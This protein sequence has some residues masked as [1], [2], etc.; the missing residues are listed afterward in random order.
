MELLTKY[1]PARL[2]P[3]SAEPSTL[4]SFKIPSVKEIKAT[5]PRPQAANSDIPNEYWTNPNL[6]LQ[7]L[8]HDY[9]SRQAHIAECWVDLLW[10]F[11]SKYIASRLQR[12]HMYPSYPSDLDTL[13]G[14][15]WE[16][17]VSRLMP[18]L[19]NLL[20]GLETHPAKA[21][22]TRET[23]ID[24]LFDRLYPLDYHN[25]IGPTL[26]EDY[27]PF[28]LHS[29]RRVNDDPKV[30][31]RARLE[32]NV[33]ATAGKQKTETML[34]IELGFKPNGYSSSEG[35]EAF[36]IDPFVEVDSETGV[37]FYDPDVLGNIKLRIGSGRSKKDYS[38]TEEESK[39]AAGRRIWS[40]TIPVKGNV[41]Q[42][43]F[44]PE[45]INGREVLV[46]FT[47]KIFSNLP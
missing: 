25:P 8:D 29:I 23:I 21:N 43:E 31:Y 44:T 39:V 16:Y 27:D 19:V 34:G 26:H 1:L 11:H 36:R 24:N 5:R 22:L 45:A 2:R 9:P 35:T 14:F 7:S 20:H 32:K 15:N 10:N 42:F 38:L 17:Q 28:Y 4:I 33:T 18:R 13:F 41:L 47:W 46:P 6:R 37:E 30:A 12:R 3:T 40:L